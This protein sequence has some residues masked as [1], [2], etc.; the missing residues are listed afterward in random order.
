MAS[1][2][3]KMSLVNGLI[4][5]MKKINLPESEKSSRVSWHRADFVRTSVR[6]PPLGP[7]AL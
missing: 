1:G 3:R 6:M 4:N 2:R 7:E 5:M